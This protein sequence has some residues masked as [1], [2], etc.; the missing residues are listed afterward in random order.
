MALLQRLKAP[1]V[2]E[3]PEGKA[4]LP[5]GP[6]S[7]GDVLRQQ[8]KALGLDLADV[9]AALRIKPAYLSAIEAGL[10]DH[11]P[12]HTYAIGFMRAYADYLGLDSA[13]V[14]RRFKQES[15]AFARKP[16]LSFPMPLGE[17]SV[18]DVGMLLVALILA[19]CGYGTWY[20]LSTGERSRPQRVAEVPVELLPPKP[21]QRPK[22]LT[23]PHSMEALAA[24]PVTASA[25]DPPAPSDT[26]S[27]ASAP[28]GLPATAAIPTSSRT[29][30]KPA[31]ASGLPPDHSE[32][33]TQTAAIARAPQSSSGAADA[34][35]RIAIRAIADSW[36][37]IRDASQSVLLRRVLK[38]GESYDVPDRSGLSMRTGNAGGLNITVDGNPALPIGPM[39]AVRRNVALEPQA[40]MAGTAVRD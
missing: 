13:E 5:S 32:D 39:G 2:E 8:R 29:L 10:P 15:T 24:P 21:E 27:A 9:A 36:V 28:A 1:F 23:V 38:A 20:Y 33:L 34:S 6:C 26:A 22:D 25:A 35:T 3:A 31:A 4:T 14:L 37:Q 40:L 18:P 19:L 17:R 12:G 7:A 11:L 30:T 16:D